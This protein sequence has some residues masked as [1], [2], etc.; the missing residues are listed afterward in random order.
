MVS[1]ELGAGVSEEV[2][3]EDDVLGEGV[4]TD[5]EESLDDGSG[6]EKVLLT[7]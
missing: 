2:V 1:A 7:E 5:E 4:Y 3:G 6:K